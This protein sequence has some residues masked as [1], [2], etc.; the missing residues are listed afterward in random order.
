MNIFVHLHLGRR[1][2]AMALLLAASGAWGSEAS[3]RARI[4]KARA[5]A[6]AVLAAQEAECRKRFAVTA[7]LTDARKQHRAVVGPLREELLVLDEKQRRQRAADRAERVRAKAES[8]SDATGWAAT[9]APGAA[10][11]PGVSS[12]RPVVR[13]KLRSTGPASDEPL[14]EWPTDSPALA[15]EKS[16]VSAS[17]VAGP[18]HS[19]K[20]LT[21]RPDPDALKKS[22]D[23]VREIEARRESVLKRNAERAAKKPNAAPLPVPAVV[24]AAP[25]ASQG[26]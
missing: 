11:E 2:L 24:P 9:P 23:R 3:E 25:A 7:C 22:S 5:E 19:K 4:N 26:R 17:A 14:T 10:S 18:A 13:P 8:A 21:P 15:A 12:P 6:D 1:T 20:R 16:S